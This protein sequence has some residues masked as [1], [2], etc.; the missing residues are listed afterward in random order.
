MKYLRLFLELLRYTEQWEYVKKAWAGDAPGAAK[1]LATAFVIIVVE[2]FIQK[3]LMGMG[4]VYNRMLKVFKA[5]KVGRIA[6]KAIAFMKTAQ[7]RT[8]GLLKKG[9]AT[10][11]NSKVAIYLEKIIVKGAHTLDDL[12]NNILTKFGFKKM[13]TLAEQMDTFFLNLFK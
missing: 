5:T 3:I 2:F 1:A 6:R 10:L 13:I 8:K 9:V 11:R 7:R 12:R 4:K